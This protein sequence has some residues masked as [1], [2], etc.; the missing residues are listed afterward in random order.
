MLTIL[1]VLYFVVVWTFTRLHLLLRCTLH[2]FHNRRSQII[3]SKA[4]ESVTKFSSY[5]LGGNILST[6]GRTVK[7]TNGNRIGSNISLSMRTIPNFPNCGST[8]A[9][10]LKLVYESIFCRTAMA[11]IPPMV[12][13]P[14]TTAP[15]DNQHTAYQA[16]MG[17]PYSLTSIL[18]FPRMV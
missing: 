18:Y 16:I 10:I 6:T 8:R 9:A 15:L 17:M 12:A 2:C 5:T 11:S 3:S 7:T 14:Y 4:E 13:S 1:Y